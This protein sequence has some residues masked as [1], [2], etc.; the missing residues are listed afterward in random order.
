MVG[1][2]YLL[3]RSFSFPELLVGFPMADPSL[4]PFFT[5]YLEQ[6]VCELR[7]DGVLRSSSEGLRQE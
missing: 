4:S 1:W 3:S 7:V 6:L 2:V 5:E